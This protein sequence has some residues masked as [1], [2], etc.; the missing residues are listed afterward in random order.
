M[1]KPKETTERLNERKE[2]EKKTTLQ[3]LIPFKQ[4]KKKQQKNKTKN[5]IK[6]K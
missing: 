3:C 4:E 5:R 6:I 1:E 2:R